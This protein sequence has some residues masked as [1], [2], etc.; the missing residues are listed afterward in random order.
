MGQSDLSK[1]HILG[2]NP[3]QHKINYK[4]HENI[5]KQLKWKEGIAVDVK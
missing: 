3:Y 2:E 5:E 4:L 1:I